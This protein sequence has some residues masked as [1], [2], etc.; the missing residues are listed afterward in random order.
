M[1]SIDALVDYCE[2]QLNQNATRI[3]E[4]TKAKRLFSAEIQNMV[5][6]RN[7][8]GHSPIGVTDPA[9]AELHKDLL[10]IELKDVVAACKELQERQKKLLNMLIS[11]NTKKGG[12][13][14]KTIKIRHK[15]V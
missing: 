9:E 15:K 6:F 10:L 12:K 13:K 2:T 1:S 5:E 14:N 4:L 7:D 8:E 3:K 11:L